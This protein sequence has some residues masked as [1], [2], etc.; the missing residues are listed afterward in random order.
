MEDKKVK[1]TLA[2]ASSA[3]AIVSSN[4]F[5]KISTFIGQESRILSTACMKFHDE[6]K[7]TFNVFWEAFLVIGANENDDNF[8]DNVKA[9][10]QSYIS[11]CVLLKELSMVLT[12]RCS[13]FALLW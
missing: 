11:K 13:F 1:Y 9:S 4:F 6:N 3:A 2:G 10:V 12:V 7:K 5:S 8:S